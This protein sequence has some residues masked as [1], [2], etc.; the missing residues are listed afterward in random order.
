MSNYE[1]LRLV[2][3]IDS[4]ETCFPRLEGCAK[5]TV[6]GGSVSVRFVPKAAARIIRQIDP[7]ISYFG[8]IG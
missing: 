6:L 3:A 5:P 8:K 4:T 7:A 2:N 1:L